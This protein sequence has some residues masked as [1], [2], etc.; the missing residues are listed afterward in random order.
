MF[1]KQLEETFQKIFQVQKVTY[2]TWDPKDDSMREQKVL[3]V[4]VE[5]CVPTFKD[6]QQLAMVTGKAVMVARSEQLPFGFFGKSID[7]APDELTKDLFFFD[8][9]GN[10]RVFR[11]IVARGF[12]FQYF[13]RSQYDPSVGT[14]TSVDIT[15]EQE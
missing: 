4:E 6:K 3:F 8:L 12:S 14:I 7:A 9:E 13:F 15:V 5:T 2:D 10:S 11:D 1:E